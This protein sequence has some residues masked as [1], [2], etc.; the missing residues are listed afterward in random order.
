MGVG[1]HAPTVRRR[2]LMATC[3]IAL[4]SLASGC[5]YQASAVSALRSTPAAATV[6]RVLGVHPSTAPGKGGTQIIVLGQGFTPATAITVGGVHARVVSVRNPGAVLAIIP[7]GIGSEVVRAVTNVGV[8][9][10]N[11]SSV[12]HF[13]NRVLVVGDSLGIDL[14]WGFTP[15]LDASHSLSVTD[16]AVG[17]S[18]LVRT[19]FYNW[20]A[21]LRADIAA[22]H[23]DVV[24]T[25]FGTNDQQVL[26]TP[27]GP[28]QP[29][30]AAWNRAYAARV[31][32]I[33][34]VVHDARATIV[35][36]S[37]PR[38]GPRAWLSPQ[39]VSDMVTLDGSV[40][41]ALPR[42]AFV[43][44]WVVF[45][46]PGGA[47]TPYVELAPNVWVLGHSGDEIHLTPAGA[48]VIVDKAVHSLHRSLLGR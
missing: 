9:A 6:P 45:T 31:R 26:G 10:A 21:H 38:M 30:T 14:G 37:L 36:V 33:T 18:G 16:E 41:S 43:N 44:S 46:T 1:L 27:S 35:W 7:P 42:A 8:S 3:A 19:D 13:T 28:A 17:S 23:A 2:L 48:T 40:V 29:G 4:G 11:S 25:M 39:I 22:T 34:A 20:P 47:Y 12:V 32:Q 24:V 5:V 15:S